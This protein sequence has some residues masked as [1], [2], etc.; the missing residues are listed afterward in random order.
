MQIF[1]YLCTIFF[2]TANIPMWSL[3]EKN[4]QNPFE[5]LKLAV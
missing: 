3:K 5:K 2:K 1:S 4:I